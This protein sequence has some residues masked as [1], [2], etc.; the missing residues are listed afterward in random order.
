MA[1]LPK[2]IFCDI[3]GTLLYHDWDTH[4]K[5]PERIL[6]PGTFEK[7]KKWDKLGYRIILTT[8]RKESTRSV[9][10]QQLKNAGI[11]YD[12]LIMGI[13]GSYRVLINDKKPNGKRNTCY[14]INLERNKGVENL[15]LETEFVTT[16]EDYKLG[17][18]EKPWGFENLIE[19]NDNYVVKE[20]FMTKGHK[21]SLQYHVL[22][23]ETVYVLK[24]SLKVYLGDEE[25]KLETRLMTPGENITIEPYKIHRMEAME[26]SL[27]LECS[28]NQLYD[29]VRL[30]DAY[31]RKLN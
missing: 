8:G 9:T 28:T 31:G 10:E 25:D 7:I 3:D 24:G 29:V 30:Q 2:T 22:K 12:Q 15:N 17:K 26:D 6:L 5:D 16:A 27:Y 13:S 18:I 23:R 21:C 14:A 11:I 20:L 1:N 4:M 19:Y